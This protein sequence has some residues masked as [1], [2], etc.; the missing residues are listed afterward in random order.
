V[1]AGRYAPGSGHCGGERRDLMRGCLFEKHEG[2]FQN[3]TL[4]AFAAFESGRH[5]EPAG[6]GFI[7]IILNL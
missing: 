2:V 6:S 7:F 5:P 4:K 1:V 3:Y